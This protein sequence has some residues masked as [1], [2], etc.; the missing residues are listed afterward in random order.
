MM[1]STSSSPPVVNMLLVYD[2]IILERFLEKVS[3]LR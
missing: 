2:H 3:I 1:A